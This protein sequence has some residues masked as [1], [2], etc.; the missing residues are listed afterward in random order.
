MLPI[1]AYILK[2][3]AFCNLNCSYCYVFNLDDHSFRGRPKVMPLE[4]VDWSAKRVVAQAREQGVRQLSIILHGGEP[5]LAG[6]DWFHR[7]VDC[8]R[9]EGGDDIYFHFAVQ[10]N[11]VLLTPS[12]IEL[13]R[14]YRM[15]VSLSLDGPPEINDR[16]RLNF[17]G[18]SS[19]AE[20]VRGLHLVK[21]E[22]F[23]GGLL[24]VIDSSADGLGVYRHFRQ[25]GVKTM[26]FLLPHEHN[27][28]K[29]PLGHAGPTATPYA[30][31]LIPVFDAWWEEDD[32]TVCVR[33][34]QTLLGYLLGNRA[35]VDALGGNPVTFAVIETEGSLEPLDV[36]RA[37][38]DGFTNLGLNVRDH[39]ISSMAEAPLYQEAVKGQDGLCQ[40]C[41]LCPLHDICGAGYLPHRY[42][43]ER[44]FDN[45]SVYCRD[46][47]KLIHHIAN[48][49]V[50]RLGAS[51]PPPIARDAV[52]H[53]A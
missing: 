7:M 47:W 51:A 17:A 19:Y 42:S 45:P 28:D 4:V 11:G 24:C 30:D 35:G 5:L 38:G 3:T 29:P 39:S 41:T 33:S 49:A 16:A 18:R 48:R 10:T 40:A 20:T 27:W 25:L 50:A 46:L 1:S 26:D 6:Q 23:F 52:I 53:A 14:Q 37:C 12:W 34:L 32:A 21:D 8:F 22:P 2:V 13:F 43:R 36:L 9:R 44:G 31:Y 15:S